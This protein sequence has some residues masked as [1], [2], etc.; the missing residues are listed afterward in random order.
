MSLELNWYKKK[1]LP[2]NLYL[3]CSL[4]FL[5]KC[6]MKTRTRQRRK[7]VTNLEL[8]GKEINK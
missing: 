7:I 3:Q 4:Y 2:V 5:C 8:R 1:K 6:K